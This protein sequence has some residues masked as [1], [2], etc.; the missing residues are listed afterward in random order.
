M[1]WDKL[2]R[3]LQFPPLL[4]E[5]LKLVKELD[6]K[7]TEIEL[8]NQKIGETCHDIKSY[9]RKMELSA[10]VLKRKH[11]NELDEESL[12]L[13]NDIQQ[14]SSQAIHLINAQNH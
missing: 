2:T 7:E 11:Q 5:L 4:F 6:K 14:E 1:F 8:H 12:G 13:L 10:E 3:V 9:L